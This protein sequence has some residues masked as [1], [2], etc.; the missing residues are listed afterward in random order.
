MLADKLFYL[1]KVK[2]DGCFTNKSMDY[3]IP[4]SKVNN[5][6]Y[7]YETKTTRFNFKDIIINAKGDIVSQTVDVLNKPYTNGIII[8][9]DGTIKELF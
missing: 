9:E 2:Y 1:K 3:L 8:E 7:C 4:L 6:T 5:I